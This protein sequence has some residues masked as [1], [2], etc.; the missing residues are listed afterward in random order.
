MVG[1]R[2]SK[3]ATSSEATRV[4]LR[5]LLLL[6]SILSVGLAVTRGALVNDGEPVQ[7]TRLR[8]GPFSGQLRAQGVI[9]IEQPEDQPPK[10]IVKFDL[11]DDRLKWVRIGQRVSIQD[12]RTQSIVA[13]GQIVKLG[14]EPVIY[15]WFTTQHKYY[16]VQ[17]EITTSV[18][19]LHSEQQVE[20][21][22]TAHEEPNALQV[23]IDTVLEFEGRCFLVVRGPKQ[24]MELK[25]IDLLGWS[26]R[27]IAI[28]E[29]LSDALPRNTQ[30]IRNPRRHLSRLGD[31]A[32]R[33]M[34]NRNVRP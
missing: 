3:L 25:Y 7:L 32:W 4:S 23:P 26:D 24:P 34:R 9:D 6:M 11:T 1:Y 20:V 8:R 31:T 33:R 14:S 5:F 12:P 13:E 27:W 28:N 30:V 18:A 29:R 21:S 19:P 22:I 15:G 17:A 16:A 10:L 2:V